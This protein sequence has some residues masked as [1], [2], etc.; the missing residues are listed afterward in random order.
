VIEEGLVSLTLTAADVHGLETYKEPATSLRIEPGDHGGTRE[1]IGS[2]ARKV[3]SMVVAPTQR[4]EH[5]L[6]LVARAWHLL[7][8]RRGR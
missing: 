2:E 6:G 1:A 8:R 4:H 3:E 5:E 7:R